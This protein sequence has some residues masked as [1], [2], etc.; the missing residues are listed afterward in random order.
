MFYLSFATIIFL[1]ALITQVAVSSMAIHWAI[2]PFIIFTH[3][4][5]LQ[6]AF[7]LSIPITIISIVV[8]ILLLIDSKSDLYLYLL[9]SLVVVNCS[10]LIGLTTPPSLKS[11][12]EKWDKKWTNTSHPMSF[13]LEKSC[14]G[15]NNFKDRSIYECPFLSRSGCKPIVEN[16][17]KMRF[18]QIFLLETVISALL[19]FSMFSFFWARYHHHIETIWAEIELPLLQ[20]NL[21]T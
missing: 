9:T 20:S 6:A 7:G 18:N 21:Y 12:I 13:Q 5:P 8:F 16:W 2:D 17:I 4:F 3:S 11:W 19:C 14:C 15:W 1:V 10:M